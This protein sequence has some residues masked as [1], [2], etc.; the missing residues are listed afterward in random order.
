MTSFMLLELD[1][2]PE[3]LLAELA[4]LA[5]LQLVVVKMTV[6]RVFVLAHHSALAALHFLLVVGHHVRFQLEDSFAA[7]VAHFRLPV[8]FVHSFDV[9]LEIIFSFQELFAEWTFKAAGFL[10][11]FLLLVPVLMHVEP[12]SGD[13]GP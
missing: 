1:V 2:L 6:E 11:N 4:L 3:R 9:H 13:A 12:L 7:N 8:V 5:L 10:D